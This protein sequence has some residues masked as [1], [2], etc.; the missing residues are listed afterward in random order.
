MK[1]VR[2]HVGGIAVLALWLV[3][4]LL[5]FQ[6]PPEPAETADGPPADSGV[7]D[8]DGT[9][10]VRSA[11]FD[12]TELP[13]AVVAAITFVF[14]DGLVTMNG[15]FAAAGDGYVPVRGERRYK[16][17]A[18]AADSVGAIDLHPADSDRA[19]DGCVPGL[20]AIERGTLTLVLNF[21]GTRPTSL[22][23]DAEST[24]RFVCER[25]IAVE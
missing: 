1:S 5:R 23:A 24:G 13:A 15:G 4:A 10:V 21:S 20:Y 11:R 8:L 19:G 9:W 22:D 3:V 25:R 18:G 12:G 6:G 2:C 16:A 7:R 17:A 14:N